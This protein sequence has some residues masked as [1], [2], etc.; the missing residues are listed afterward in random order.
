[1]KIAYLVWSDEDDQFPKL[2]PE[3][4]RELDYCYRR[5]RIVYAELEEQP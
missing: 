4:S 3:H 2:V 5:V 1:M